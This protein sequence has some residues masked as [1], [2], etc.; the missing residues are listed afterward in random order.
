V[1]TV[2]LILLVVWGI[3]AL[4]A[5]RVLGQWMGLAEDDDLDLFDL[6]LLVPPVVFLGTILGPLILAFRFLDHR[7]QNPAAVGRA[8]FGE[9][10]DQRIERLE[11][12]RKAREARIARLER[13]LG[14]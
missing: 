14:L 2:E 1:S 6:V 5:S 12:E 8:L 13:E 4:P 10:K 11:R 7:V 9:S 3:C